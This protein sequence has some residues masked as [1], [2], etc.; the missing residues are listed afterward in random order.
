M[1]IRKIIREEYNKL[2][3]ASD[4]YGSLANPKNIDPNDPEIIVKG[5]GSYSRTALR[6]SI[7]SR[8]SELSKLAKSA[9]TSTDPET[10][11]R[12]MRNLAA[13]L[14]TNN[15]LYHMVKAD[16]DVAEQLESIRTKGGRRSMPIPK[17]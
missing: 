13:A 10:A 7:A 2:M 16:V 14:E 3:E 6:D 12:L 4:Q 8:L 5:F 11:N 17:Q 15:A 1:N 9:N